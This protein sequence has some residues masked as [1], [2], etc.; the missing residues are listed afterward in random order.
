MAELTTIA[1]PYAE[2]AFRLARENDALPVWSEML[3]FM[4]GVVA[5]PQIAATLD[6]PRLG[7]GDKEALLLS[8]AGE[9]VGGLGRNF[10]R[11]LVEA[12]RVTLLPDI[13]RLFDGFKADAEGVAK[14]IVDTAFPLDE[15]QTRE[16]MAALERRFGK[17]IEFAVNV[18]RSLIGGVRIAVGDTVIDGSVRAKLDA[19]HVQLRA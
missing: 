10:L 4:A 1:R 12:D 8:V 3:R 2:A 5:D 17:R 6:N 14:A 13:S 19:M 7:A 9:R 16:L 18:D 15:V 11:V